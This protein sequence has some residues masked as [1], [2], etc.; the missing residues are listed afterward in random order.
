MIVGMMIMVVGITMVLVMR[1]AES[2]MMV[3]V[4]IMVL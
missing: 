3:L 4:V 2:L 1:V